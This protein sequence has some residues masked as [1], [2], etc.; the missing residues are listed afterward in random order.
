VDRR[1]AFSRLPRRERRL[2]VN[3]AVAL[4]SAQRSHDQSR[5]KQRIA[6]PTYISI[7]DI[8]AHASMRCTSVIQAVSGQLDSAS[9]EKVSNELAVLVK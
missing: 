5:E 1:A 4:V 6:C 2:D 8:D 3:R 7:A 9:N